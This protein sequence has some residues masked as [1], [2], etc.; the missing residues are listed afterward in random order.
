MVFYFFTRLINFF[1][2]LA[3]KKWLSDVS[4]TDDV[5]VEKK[6]QKREI[7]GHKKQATAETPM[8]TRAIELKPAFAEQEDWSKYESPAYE[9][10]PK[11]KPKRKAA[12][13]KKAAATE[14]NAAPNSPSQQRPRAQQL[15]QWQAQRQAANKTAAPAFEEI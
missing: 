6:Q 2:K 10:N 7:V 1:M 5:K 9:R 13:A 14:A 12:P 3:S 11:V 4:A 8:A 15:Q